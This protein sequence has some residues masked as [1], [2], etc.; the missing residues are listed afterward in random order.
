[1]LAPVAAS[2]RLRRTRRV[3][4]SPGKRVG[5]RASRTVVSSAATFDSAVAEGLETI[6]I[7]YVYVTTSEKA[8]FVSRNDPSAFSVHFCGFGK[9]AGVLV[10]SWGQI[11]GEASGRSV[12]RSI[13][14]LTIGGTSVGVPVGSKVG[15]PVVGAALTGA[16]V[17]GASVTGAG[18][19]G[20]G[21]GAGV[22]LVCSGSPPWRFW[23]TTG[24]AIEDRT[25]AV[26]QM[27]IM[28]FIV[29][30]L[31]WVVEKGNRSDDFGSSFGGNEKCRC[32]WRDEVS[33]GMALTGYFVRTLQFEPVTF[34]FVFAAV[35]AGL[36]LNAFLNSNF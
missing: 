9:K 23:E 26:R 29:D 11:H 19:T 14:D 2:R 34:C 20:A 27:R 16:G 31:Q 21:V 8:G 12:G 15:A 3:H 36:C 22:T 6:S 35:N 4:P 10:R 5:S 24:I 7:S 1:M 33:G 18:V 30:W 32:R 28:V 13:K 17:T 25:R